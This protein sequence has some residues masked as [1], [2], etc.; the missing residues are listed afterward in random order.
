MVVDHLNQHT[1]L[2]PAN[3]V[4]V[5]YRNPNEI[6][7]HFLDPYAGLSTTIWNERTDAKFPDHFKFDNPHRVDFNFPLIAGFVQEGRSCDP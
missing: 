6:R 3:I 1:G 5:D 4:M 2:T 7:I